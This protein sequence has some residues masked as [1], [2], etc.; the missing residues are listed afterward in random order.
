MTASPGSAMAGYASP[1]DNNLLNGPFHAVIGFP[2]TLNP[3]AVTLANGGNTTG[4]I[5]VNSVSSNHGI[6]TQC[7]YPISASRSMT[8]CS[9]AGPR[10][11]LAPGF[12]T[13]SRGL[14][15]QSAHPLTFTQLEASNC[16]TRPTPVPTLIGTISLPTA[17]SNHG[18]NGTITIAA[19]VASPGSR[20]A[21]RAN[22][23]ELRLPSGATL[24]LALAPSRAGTMT[25]AVKHQLCQDSLHAE[26]QGKGP[27]SSYS[28][29]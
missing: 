4:S 22:G 18:S 2:A 23:A 1:T 14:A 29:F 16:S 19:S 5:N 26:S 24:T 3:S 8:S 25:P 17:S 27:F 7:G 12:M 9:T 28:L 10:L 20:A 13:T 6:T 15:C 21:T 11:R